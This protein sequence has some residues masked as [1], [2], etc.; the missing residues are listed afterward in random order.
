M[1]S[2]EQLSFLETIE[3]T[4]RID[5]DK[6]F[7]GPIKPTAPRNKKL[8]PN[9]RDKDKYIL[10]YR[11]LKFYLKMKMKIKRVHRILAFDQSPWLKSYIDFNTAKRAEA[12]S[13]FEK[14]FFK[15]LNNSV[16]GKT[17]ENIRNHRKL[18]FIGTEKRAEKFAAQPTFRN[19][20]LFHENLIAI[21]RYKTSIYFDRPIYTGFSVLDISKILMFDFHYQTIKEKYPGDKSTLC[22]TDTDSFLYKIKTDDIYMDMLN[23]F[24]MY[25]FSDYADDHPCFSGLPPETVE[26]IKSTNKKTVGKFKDEEKGIAITEFIGIRAKCYSYKR[27]DGQCRKKL[28]GIKKSVVKQTIQHEHYRQ[29]LFDDQQLY[30]SMNTFRS[31]NHQLKTIRQTK[32]ALLNFDDKRH[33]LSCGL[34]T[35]AHGHYSIKY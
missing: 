5:T 8:T 24:Q 18:D 31:Y 15:L 1:L 33:L 35:M 16:F 17:C 4:R 9:L 28:K 34:K 22:F 30:A 26:H 10:H 21:E 11:N 19:Y 6:N 2:T 23:D 25:D 32:S 13:E 20:H 3:R 12:K 7:I 14:S 27:I 29:C